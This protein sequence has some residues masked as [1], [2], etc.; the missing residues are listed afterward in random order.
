M[1]PN[2]AFLDYLLIVEDDAEML[3]T[4]QEILIHVTPNILVA[5]NGPEALHLASK[6]NVVALVSDVNMPGI[7]GPELV[8]K[9]R[10]RQISAP[11]VLLSGGSHADPALANAAEVYFVPKP[12]PV[13]ELIEV[14]KGAFLQGITQSSKLRRKRAAGGDT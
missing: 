8:T 3:D 2:C 10:A 13:R 6:F 5:K 4:L 11:A 1:S 7:S 12:F 9:L 14:V